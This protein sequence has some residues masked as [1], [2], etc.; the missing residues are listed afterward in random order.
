MSVFIEKKKQSLDLIGL[1][2]DELIETPLDYNKWTKLIKQVLV[3]DKE[4]QIRSVFNRYLNIFKFDGKQW[5]NYI[6]FEMGR[7]DSKKIEELFSKCIATVDNV[8]LFRLYVSYVRRVNDVI[9]GGEKARGVVIQAFEFSVNRVGLDIKSDELWNDYLEFLKSWTPSASWEQQQKI[10]LIRK[11]YKKLLVIPTENIERLWSVYTKW[12]NE[13]N[14]ATSSRFIADKSSEFMEARSWNVEWHN[15]TNKLLI[16]DI[17]PYSL[18][19]EDSDHRL[20]VSEQIKLWY[21]WIDFEKRNSLNIKD[22][23][24][25]QKRIEYVYKQAIISLPFVPELWYRY[26]QYLLIKNESRTNDEAASNFNT[27]FEL[28]SQGL[29]LNPQSYL[30]SFEI[31]ELYEKDNNLPKANEILTN[32]IQSLTKDHTAIVNSIEEIN[33]KSTSSNS[34]P[35]NGASKS[36]TGEDEEN[37]NKLRISLSPTDIK[38]L[39]TL[40]SKEKELSRNITLVYTKQMMTNKRASGIT[41]SRNIFKQAKKFSRIGHEL[42]VE[43]ALMEYYSDKKKTA[44]KVFE[45]G[46]KLY[47]TNG[48]FLLAYLDYLIMINEIESIKVLF[49]VSLTNLLNEIDNPQG[50]DDLDTPEWI[51]EENVAKLEEYKLFVKKLIKTYGKFATN[52]LDLGI[53]VSLEKRFRQYFPE[54]DSLELI[55]SRYTYDS[56]DLINYDLGKTPKDSLDEDADDDEQPKSK[57]LKIDLPSKP[58]VK[59]D[60]NDSNGIVSQTETHGFI[61][62]SIYN[63]LRV[64]P[65]ASYFGM[66]EDQ[67]FNSKKLVELLNSL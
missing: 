48:K 35:E 66:P 1:L 49:E 53:V 61:G 10:D 15:I 45:L 14:S 12:E 44:N 37:Q 30:I 65:N 59:S 19:D 11:V 24:V 63:L 31:S 42:Y 64:L 32:L 40:K 51:K 23:N 13:I 67:V 27:N 39:K 18:N 56:I 26:N 16:R 47:G 52:F 28:L 34:K 5:Y 60:N 4:G 22:D 17:V 58:L 46:L 62:N 29:I 7:G 6:S 38:N 50:I 9:T 2:E 33:N 54:D 55:R 20:L 8:D 36:E 21:Q 41:E 57:K 3:K 25:L 43:N